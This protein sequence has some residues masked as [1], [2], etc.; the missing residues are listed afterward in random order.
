MKIR[1]IKREKVFI[2]EFEGNKEL[3][4]NEQVKIE[5]KSFPSVIQVAEYKKYSYGRD[6]TTVVSYKYDL[7]FRAIAKANNGGTAFPIWIPI[8]LLPP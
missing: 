7:I 3:P 2:P 4:A 5:I 1:S 6:L 8:E